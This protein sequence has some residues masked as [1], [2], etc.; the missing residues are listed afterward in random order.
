MATFPHVYPSQQTDSVDSGE[1]DV[2]SREIIRLL[3]EDGRKSTADL[4]RELGVA[5]GTVRRKLRRLLDSRTIA[6]K[7]VVDPFCLGQSI[8]ATIGLDVE[9][10]CLDSVADRLAGYAFVDQV[11]LTT[12]PFDIMIE[13]TMNSVAHLYSF[14]LDELASVKGI[15]DTE[16][17]LIGRVYKR[18]GLLR[19]RQDAAATP[20]STSKGDEE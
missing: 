5:E 19:D 14:L 13:V 6:V 16:T 9:R 3:R 12:G 1:V 11:Y 4:A 20:Q 17:Y 15:T 7:A 10:H 2:V 8:S 18:H